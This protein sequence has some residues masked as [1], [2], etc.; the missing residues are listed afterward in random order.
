MIIEVDATAIV[1]KARPEPIEIS[2]SGDPTTPEIVLGRV[3]C[4]LKHI[5]VIGALVGLGL[6][7]VSAIF[8]I[9]DNTKPLSG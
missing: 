1:S 9:I 7:A 6:V 2:S 5:G 4:T 8:V 3:G